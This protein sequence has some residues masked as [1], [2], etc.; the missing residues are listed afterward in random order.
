M[1]TFKTKAEKVKN[2]FKDNNP[3]VT[4]QIMLYRAKVFCDLKIYSA[5]T[6]LEKIY[7]RKI[8]KHIK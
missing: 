1:N 3:C 4:N 7:W 6:E 2:I 5:F 8:K